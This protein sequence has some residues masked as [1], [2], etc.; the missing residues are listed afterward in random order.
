M[1]SKVTVAEIAELA[2]KLCQLEA[3]ITRTKILKQDL[4]SRY[5]C[6]N[7]FFTTR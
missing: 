2:V 5:D 1:T 6:N 3:R 4:I 7:S